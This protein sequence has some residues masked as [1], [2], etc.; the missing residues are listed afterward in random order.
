MGE[1]KFTFMKEERI[2]K[3]YPDKINKIRYDID[4]NIKMITDNNEAAVYAYE[5]AI[6]NT[7]QVRDELQNL[8]LTENQIVAGLTQNQAEVLQAKALIDKAT[9]QVAEGMAKMNIIKKAIKD[10]EQRLLDAESNKPIE[11]ISK[12]MIKDIN[13]VI[14]GLRDRLL[15]YSRDYDD[16]KINYKTTKSEYEKALKELND[17]DVAIDNYKKGIKPPPKLRPQQVRAQQQRDYERLLESTRTQPRDEDEDY[18]PPPT[19]KPGRRGRKPLILKPV[20]KSPVRKPAVI[21]QVINEVVKEI[22]KQ[23]EEDEDYVPP[24]RYKP[25]RKPE[26]EPE[27]EEDEEDEED[28]EEEEVVFTP[29]QLD[30]LEYFKLKSKGWSRTQKEHDRYDELRSRLGL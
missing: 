20:K 30:K 21:K 11:P 7:Q 29:E 9:M 10:E 22:I 3:E 25:G 28:E 13:K 1:L 15:K 14:D 6:K 16:A 26:P 8:K 4:K 18:V 12:I 27:E 17:I 2:L 24:P 5:E 19:Y 23:P